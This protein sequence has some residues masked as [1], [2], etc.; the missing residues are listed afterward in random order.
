MGA[1]PIQNAPGRPGVALLTNLYFLKAP[2]AS[3]TGLFFIAAADS[4]SY[5]IN[6]YFL[7]IFSL[8]H[9]FSA[10]EVKAFIFQCIEH[11]PIALFTL[12]TG[13]MLSKSPLLEAFR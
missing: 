11:F 6:W 8:P 2:C 7:C 1:S 13:S 9:F 4:N 3:A 12:R 5:L 10:V